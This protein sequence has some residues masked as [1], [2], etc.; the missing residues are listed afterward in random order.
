[1]NHE[2]DGEAQEGNAERKGEWDGKS[3]ERNEEEIERHNHHH[4]LCSQM[5]PDKRMFV[6]T[7]PDVVQFVA[8]GVAKSLQALPISTCDVREPASSLMS[9]K[10]KQHYQT[11]K[12]KEK[13]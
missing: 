6:A 3:K 5:E 12:E 4:H 8:E 10:M 7:L 13:Q 9:V 11:L 1:V 2:V